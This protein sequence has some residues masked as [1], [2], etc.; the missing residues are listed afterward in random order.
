L[1]TRAEVARVA[2]W[3]LLT[4]ART[5]DRVGITIVGALV[6]AAVLL[7]VR[8]LGAP[9]VPTF[10]PTV[11]EPVEVGEAKVARTVTVDASDP[12]VWQ[13][14]DFS[15]GSVVTTPGS[16]NWDI[17]FRRFHVVANGGVGFAGEAGIL[18]IGGA[19]FD[20]ISVVPSEG[21]IG[22]EHAG[23]STN[24]AIERWYEYSWTSHLLEPKPTVYAIRTADG[25]HAK[26]RIL[27]YYCTGARPGCVTFQYVY[28]GAGGTDVA[29]R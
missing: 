14:F 19:A 9:D 29:S 26:L 23:D 1:A 22:N 18:E 16:A 25:R 5:R 3:S 7:V 8:S 17:A 2:D 4:V 27:G 13:F 21:Y 12:D 15:S 20:S 10:L 24:A 28:Q 11:I 6:L